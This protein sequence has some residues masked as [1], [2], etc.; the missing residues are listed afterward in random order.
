MKAL[1]FLDIIVNLKVVKNK[2]EFRDMNRPLYDFFANDHHRLDQLLDKA[3]LHL[4]H[5]DE[6][7]YLSFRVGLLTH[8]KMEEKILF[9]AAKRANGGE[10]IPNFT[11]LRA[12]HGAIT[13]LMVPPP[14]PSLLKVLQHILEKHD[15][16]EEEPGGAYEI[17]E[18]LTHNETD[19]LLDQLRNITLV[20]VNPHNHSEYALEAAKRAV[21]RAG[22]DYDAIANEEVV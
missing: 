20:P 7:Y 3:T 9:P 10:P 13:S 1:E 14:T 4:P 18:L 5:I 16:L 6:T 12:D 21:N 17:C 2:V 8:I 19:A 11:K 15:L 22:Y